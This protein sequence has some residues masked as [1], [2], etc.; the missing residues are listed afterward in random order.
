MVWFLIGGLRAVQKY[1]FYGLKYPVFKWSDL[2]MWLDH[3]KLAKKFRK[4]DFGFSNGYC[5][6]LMNLDLMILFPVR[7][8]FWG[9]Y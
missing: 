3:L 1:M 5:T 4:V 2:I 7:A 9:I 6:R 8:Y